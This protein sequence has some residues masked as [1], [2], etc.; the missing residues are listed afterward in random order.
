MFY[1]KRC[2][3]CGDCLVECQWM[4]VERDQAVAWMEAM[5][6]GRWPAGRHV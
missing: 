4:G 5:I 6:A 3:R 2:D 1:P